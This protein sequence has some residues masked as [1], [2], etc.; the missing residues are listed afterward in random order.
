[1]EHCHGYYWKCI[2]LVD[3]HVW[4]TT[5]GT[6]LILSNWIATMLFA[7]I[8]SKI[9][10]RSKKVLDFSITLAFWHLLISVCF[11]GFTMPNFTWW[12]TVIL[13]VSAGT[14]LSEYLCMKME[15]MDIQLTSSDF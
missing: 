4:S 6:C 12:G 7:P 1:M 15:M 3:N 10:E 13:S 9:V 2:F 8:M 11:S 5:L 14:L